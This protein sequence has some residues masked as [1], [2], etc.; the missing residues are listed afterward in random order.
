MRLI[1]IPNDEFDHGL[2]RM[3]GILEARGEIV[4][5]TVQD[6]EPAEGF[7]LYVGGG[8]GPDQKIGRE[9]FR[10]ILREDTPKAVER[11]LAAYLGHRST[12]EETFFEFSNRHDTEALQAL[13]GDIAG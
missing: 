12:A 11:L 4:V 7:H 6:A 8:S 13:V 1:E 2:T 5:L 10:D 9:L 3:Q